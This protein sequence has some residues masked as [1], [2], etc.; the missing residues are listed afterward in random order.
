VLL[1][2]QV[3]ADHLAVV[4]LLLLQ[5]EV[6]AQGRQ[7]EE[8]DRPTQAAELADQALALQVQLVALE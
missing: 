3:V 6:V 1:A 4:V 8:L 7:Q 2:L 5:Q